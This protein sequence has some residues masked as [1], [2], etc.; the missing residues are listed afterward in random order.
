MGIRDFLHSLSGVSV[1]PRTSDVLK[2]PAAAENFFLPPDYQSRRTVEYFHDVTIA[3]NEP[4]WQP[5]VY[6]LADLI[7]SLKGHR[8]IDVGCGKGEKLRQIA[9]RHEVFGIDFGENISFCRSKNDFGQW[10]E[11]DL[12]S[13]EDLPLP[14][15]LFR[16]AVVICSDVIEHVLNPTPLLRK[17]KVTV[18]LGATLLL[19]TPERDLERGVRHRGPPYN[20]SHVREWSLAE[21]RSLLQH[22]GFEVC[23]LGTTANNERDREMVTSLAI[24]RSTSTS[25]CSEEKPPLLEPTA[26]SR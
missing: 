11:H 4:A 16:D 19:S 13:S 12:D 1:L 20:S 14:R 15:G 5:D 18:D 26:P 24:L 10:F 3:D 2:A 17:L 23:Y 9:T 22:A 25:P 21:L 6:R 7:A 8:I